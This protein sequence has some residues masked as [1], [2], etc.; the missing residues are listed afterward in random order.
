MAEEKID[1]NSLEGEI[2]DFRGAEKGRKLQLFFFHIY[3][4]DSLWQFSL[5]SLKLPAEL[6]RN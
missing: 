3:G 5:G 6:I 2:G 1:E 4:H